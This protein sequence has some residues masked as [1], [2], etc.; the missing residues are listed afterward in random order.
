M[1]AVFPPPKTQN[2][3]G[4]SENRV[5]GNETKKKHQFMQRGAAKAWGSLKFPPFTIR[6]ATSVPSAKN[7]IESEFDAILEEDDFL[8]E[9]P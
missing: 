4:I 7:A 5:F 6:P 2:V 8:H 9:Y 3:R 1:S